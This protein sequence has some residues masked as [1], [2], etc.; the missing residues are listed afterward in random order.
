MTRT[1][2]D[3]T[4]IKDI[5]KGIDIDCYVVLI[6]LVFNNRYGLSRTYYDDHHSRQVDWRRGR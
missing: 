1:H 2:V 6:R 5:V 3:R 4:V